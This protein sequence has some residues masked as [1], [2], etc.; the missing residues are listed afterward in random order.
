MSRKTGSSGKTVKKVSI[1]KSSG[2]TKK[3]AAAAPTGGKAVGGKSAGKKAV[4]K[5]RRAGRAD[6]ATAVI[7]Q[8]TQDVMAAIDSLHGQMNAAMAKLTELAAIEA[9]DHHVVVRTAPIDRATATFQRIVAEVV[10]DQLAEML[11]PLVSLRNEMGQRADDESGEDDFARRGSETLDHVLKLAGVQSFE[12][13]AGEPVD[14]V[15]HL[16]VGEAHRGDLA[17]GVVAETVQRGFRTG[18]GR[19]VAPVRVRVNRR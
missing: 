9:R 10:D 6:S 18:R 2:K 19:I 8:T 16:V 13:R 4:S 7:D 14:P 1:T 17:D 5:A 11:G 15:I 12:A 3:K